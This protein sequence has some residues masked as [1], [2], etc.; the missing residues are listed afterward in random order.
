MIYVRLIYIL[1]VSLPDIIR[2]IDEIKKRHDEE[3]TKDKIKEDINAI[4]EAFKNRDADALR[5][6]F[7]S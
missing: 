3:A 4:K 7:N 5:K 1:I 2:L 6:L